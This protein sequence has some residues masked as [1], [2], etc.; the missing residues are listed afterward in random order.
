MN[1][2]Y[3]NDK[4]SAKLKIHLFGISLIALIFLAGQLV[5]TSPQQ[6]IILYISSFG[7]LALLSIIFVLSLPLLAKLKKNDFTVNLLKNRRWM[8]I[9]TF[10]FA[11]IHVSLVY[12]FFFKW[13]L[14]K[15]A[16]NPYRNLGLVSFLILIALAATSNNKAVKLFGKNWKRLHYLLYLVLILILV[17]SAKIGMVFMKKPVIQVIVGLLVGIILAGKISRSKAAKK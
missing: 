12:N 2:D 8:G 4:M 15:A 14:I 5:S 1:I 6:Q 3:R 13:D 7:F 17:H 10:L 16:G 11:L 9:Y